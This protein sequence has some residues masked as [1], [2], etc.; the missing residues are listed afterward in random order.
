[1]TNALATK[2]AHTLPDNGQWT[3]RFE[4]RSETSNRVYIVS[5]NKA[6][7][8]WGCSCMGWV[9][10]RKCKHL[11]ALALPCYQQPFEITRAA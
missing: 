11:R 10:Y 3:N 2:L 1:M 7:R 5:Q 9:R 8:W 4:V 6:G